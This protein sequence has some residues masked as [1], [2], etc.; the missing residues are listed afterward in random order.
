MKR[1][2]DITQD[3]ATSPVVDTIDQIR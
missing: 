1:S 3:A 2:L